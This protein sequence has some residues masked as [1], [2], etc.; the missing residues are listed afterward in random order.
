MTYISF[1]I[2]GCQITHD[3][4]RWLWTLFVPEMKVSTEVF[5]KNHKLNFFVWALNY[6]ENFENKIRANCSRELC[7]I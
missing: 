3:T 7:E 2:A 6:F 1:D 4:K 5:A